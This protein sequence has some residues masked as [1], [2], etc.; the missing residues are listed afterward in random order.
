MRH[1][2]QY[3]WEW[4]DEVELADIVAADLTVDREPPARLK[5]EHATMLASD[6]TERRRICDM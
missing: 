6:A 2:D 5:P 3:N 1:L 4:L